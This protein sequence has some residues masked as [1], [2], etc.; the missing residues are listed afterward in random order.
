[1]LGSVGAA[2]RLTLDTEE[3]SLFRLQ[4]YNIN[5]PLVKFLVLKIDKMIVAMNDRCDNKERRPKP[6]RL[7]YLL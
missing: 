6:P 4:S 2:S 7:I 1:M 3:F 5:P